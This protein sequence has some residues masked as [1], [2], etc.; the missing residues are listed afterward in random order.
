MGQQQNEY[1]FSATVCLKVI[2]R[3]ENHKPIFSDKPPSEDF[4]A[5]I[6]YGGPDA[7]DCEFCGRFHAS[8][9]YQAP[10]NG[11]VGEKIFWHEYSSLD[12]GLLDNKTFVFDCPCNAA[13]FYEKF[14]WQHL[15]VIATYSRARAARKCAEAQ[16]KLAL[17]ESVVP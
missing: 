13:V 14:F 10:K 11:G 17:A 4:L 1:R 6:R 7:H 12:T 2:R 15:P 5:A 9:E 8:Q 16:Q 3:D